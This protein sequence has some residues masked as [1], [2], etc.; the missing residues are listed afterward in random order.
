MVFFF[1]IKDFLPICGQAGLGYNQ[2]R[3]C[4]E[5]QAVALVVTEC[6]IVTDQ[7]RMGASFI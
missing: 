7:S 5:R 4:K 1:A 6:R 3:V 2:W